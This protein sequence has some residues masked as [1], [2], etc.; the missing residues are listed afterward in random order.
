MKLLWRKERREEST[1]QPVLRCS[2]CNKSQHHVRK[3]ITGPM[4]NICAEC[5]DI[6]VDIL[7]EDE[8]EGVTFDASA[9]DSAS[10]ISCGLCHRV[11]PLEKAVAIP[12]R[13]WVCLACCEAVRESRH[14]VPSK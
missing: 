2:F 9:G 6:C 3:L 8:S 5:V 11:T 4:V 7:E 14:D 1:A 10:A 12:E 13:G